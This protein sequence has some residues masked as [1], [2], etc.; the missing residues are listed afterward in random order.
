[1]PEN[2]ISMHLPHRACEMEVGFFKRRK[3]LKRISAQD[4]V[5]VHL[6]EHE[7]GEDRV[8]LL[9]P[10]FKSSWLSRAMKPLNRK[11]YIRIKLD[12]FGSATWLLIDGIRTVNEITNTLISTPPG[13]LDSE[14]DLFPRVNQF[15][16]M[17]YQQRFITFRQI[18]K[19]CTNNS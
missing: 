16:T 11:P 4:L 1:M 5:P 9:L 18:Q 15:M 6:L 7:S 19:P 14:A 2:P 17:L 3:I 10:R 8:Y 12:R 13:Q